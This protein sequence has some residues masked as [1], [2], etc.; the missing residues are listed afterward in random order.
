MVDLPF[1]VE[2]AISRGSRLQSQRVKNNLR[3]RTGINWTHA[4][5]ER[6]NSKWGRM[7]KHTRR[8]VRADKRHMLYT[9]YGLL[10]TMVGVQCR[11]ANYRYLLACMKK[12][13]KESDDLIYE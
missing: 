4:K 13:A 6:A 12:E 9:S 7:A 10:G 5:F 8:T 1:L 3:Q 2:I 11:E